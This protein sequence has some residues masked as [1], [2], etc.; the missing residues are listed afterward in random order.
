MQDVTSF[1]PQKIEQNT[2]VQELMNNPKI[3]D[4]MQKIQQKIPAQ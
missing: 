1:D 2:S 4:L 3:Q